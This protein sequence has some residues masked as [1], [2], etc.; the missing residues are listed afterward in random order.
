[1]S[2]TYSTLK[3]AI[4]DYMES[5]ESSLVSN[6][7]NFIQ[8]AE[9]RIL[10][11]V[12]LDDFKKNVTGTMTSSSPYLTTPT[13]FLAPF[14]LSVTDSSGN[15]NFLLLKQ[16]SFIR[17]YSPSPSTTGLPKYYADFDRDWE[18]CFYSKKL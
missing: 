14:S 7:D 4:Q 18:T 6:L 8:T 16:V 12:Q 2:W 17:D 5:T 11:N 9:E 15:Y 10:K 13:D 3:T 1:M